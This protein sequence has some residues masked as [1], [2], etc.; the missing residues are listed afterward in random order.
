M[1]YKSMVLILVLV[2]SHLQASM[3][4]S[5]TANFDR[6]PDISVEI[7]SKLTAKALEP[8]IL[9]TG[10]SAVYDTE[11][12]APFCNILEILE[13][14][15]VVNNNK[16]K[17]AVK[18]AKSN[19]VPYG[20]W[21]DPLKWKI[22]K[23]F[24]ADAEISFGLIG[25]DAYAFMITEAIKA[26]KDVVTNF[27]IDNMTQVAEDVNIIQIED[28]IVNGLPITYLRIDATIMGMRINYMIYLFCGNS[29]I[30]QIYT[31]SYGNFFLELEDFLN[32]ISKAK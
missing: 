22:T 12:N 11:M 31:Y 5:L 23:N 14:K 10:M 17:K 20:I 16:N 1:I 18:L 9:N 26:P 3:H 24:N 7:I 28:R 32:G 30:I 15:G 13:L 2:A 25:K 8:Q 21:Y 27:V 19:R 6:M 4:E 29:E